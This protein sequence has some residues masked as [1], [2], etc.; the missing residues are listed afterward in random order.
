MAMWHQALREAEKRLRD[1]VENRIANIFG[2]TLTAR[3][4]E[5]GGDDAVQTGDGEDTQKTVRRIE[6][7]GH[8]GRAPSKVR[9]L[10]LKLG[11]SNVFFIGVA[12]N[13]AYGPQDLE[14]GE[15]AL[16]N[17]VADCLVHLDK[18]GNVIV[19]KGERKVARK[20]DAISVGTLV[21]QAGPF[22]VTH[23]YTPT[24]ASGT[25]GTAPGAP[26]VGPTA[27]L[28]GVISAG[29]SNFKG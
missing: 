5:L 20:T 29:A 15:T 22:P 14:D 11:T 1:Y 6:P 7:W 18:D 3:S 2:F 25:D 24:V 10:Q 21:S 26:S 16:Y 28:A 12:S 4:S 13:A 19:N 9:S 23:T 17:T 8:R 27:T